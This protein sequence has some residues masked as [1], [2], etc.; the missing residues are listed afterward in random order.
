MINLG[1]RK[2]EVFIGAKDFTR[3]VSYGEFSNTLFDS[4][5]I[6]RAEGK[7]TLIKVFNADESLDPMINQVRFAR[8]TPVKIKITNTSDVLNSLPNSELYILNAQIK[9]YLA[10]ELELT[11]GC[12][13][14][15]NEWQTSNDPE[16]E[17]EVESDSEK[18]EYT[19]QELLT[20]FLNKISVGSISNNN[21]IGNW[22]GSISSDL[23]GSYL[24]KAGKIA[25]ESDN[26]SYLICDGK[27]VSVVNISLT[28]PIYLKYVIG[29]NELE[30]N[31]QTAEPPVERYI[32]TANPYLPK[33]DSEWEPDEDGCVSRS[34]VGDIVSEFWQVCRTSTVDSETYRL[35]E[36]ESIVNPKSDATTKVLS[37]RRYKAKYYDL[38]GRLYRESENVTR[39]RVA[40]LSGAYGALGI[41]VPDPYGSFVSEETD[42]NYYFRDEVTISIIKEI[43]RTLG[44]ICPEIV[45]NYSLEG[46]FTTKRVCEKEVT[47]WF[48]DVA[49]NWIKTER[50]YRSRILAYPSTVALLEGQGAYDMVNLASNL[51]KIPLGD[52]GLDSSTNGQ[53]TP[54]APSYKS[55]QETEEY[56]QKE[57]KG[58]ANFEPYSGYL[59]RPQKIAEGLETATTEAACY[60]CAKINGAI[61]YGR[62]FGCSLK[63]F[64]DDKFLNNTYLPLKR[65]D[66]VDTQSIKSYLADGLAIVFDRS[67]AYAAFSHLIW[68]GTVPYTAPTGITGNRINIRTTGSGLTVGS[69]ITF[70]PA[71]SGSVPENLVSGIPYYVVGITSEGVVVSETPGG[72]PIFPGPMPP[73]TAL[74]LT[75]PYL[76]PSGAIVPSEPAYGGAGFVIVTDPIIPPYYPED[77]TAGPVEIEIS[78]KI[79]LK[80]EIGGSVS[81]RGIF[82]TQ[83]KSFLN[84]LTSYTKLTKFELQLKPV[85]GGSVSISAVFRINQTSFF[86]VRY[87]IRISNIFRSELKPLVNGLVVTNYKISL[88]SFVGF[89]SG[90]AAIAEFKVS[91]KPELS[92]RAYV[93][94]TFKSE[95]NSNIAQ[96]AYE[97]IN[98]KS[99][100]KSITGVTGYQ[101]GVFQN[102]LKL[103][104]LNPV[105]NEEEMW[106]FVRNRSMS[107]ARSRQIVTAARLYLGEKLQASNATSRAIFSE[108]TSNNKSNILLI[109]QVTSSKSTLKFNQ[110]LNLSYAYMQLTNTN[111]SIN[112]RNLRVLAYASY[113]RFIEYP[114]NQLPV[115]VQAGVPFN[116]NGSGVFISGTRR[117]GQLEMRV[118]IP[119]SVTFIGIYDRLGAP[120]FE[121]SHYNTLIATGS[122]IIYNLNR[123]FSNES[124]FFSTPTGQISLIIR[125]V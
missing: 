77:P 67:E 52:S 92:G 79:E 27:N 41:D 75:D 91:L 76:D 118:V 35:L 99:D 7:L 86:D 112:S 124:L 105:T 37:Q 93:A 42:T 97:L 21:L 87:G 29:E 111:G 122:R 24:E 26:S 3:Y 44:E 11:L 117:V 58:V 62:Y 6:I 18:K 113:E 114:S 104:T 8:G 32:C 47:T 2:I 101:P 80:T 123:V 103:V 125:G 68:I 106:I 23:Q 66:I 22:Y 16:F 95:I 38:K 10:Q 9:D 70:Y 72:L 50:K 53:N 120:V 102:Q 60:S 13:F 85:L 119:F 31:P 71:P 54:P 82:S 74:P 1:A 17:N 116:S 51:V 33:T 107:A 4:S 49:G 19:R 40:F 78:P 46:N 25:F 36:E 61:L 84:N 73:T 109:P 45:A 56:E 57:L 110:N 90:Y 69:S 94:A 100:I 98:A 63:F 108:F 34:S 20:Y 30:W 81:V 83:L 96:T 39:P 28:P 12:W 65:V 88:S 115:I 15:L 59:Y 5:G 121:T 89:N 64:I 55:K 48:K 14:S 43:R